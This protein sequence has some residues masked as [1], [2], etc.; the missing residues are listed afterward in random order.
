MRLIDYEKALKDVLNILRG[1]VTTVTAVLVTTA[2]KASTVDA[3]EVVRCKDCEHRKEKT[4]FHPC[5]GMWVGAELKDNDF[6]SYGE[7]KEK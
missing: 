5:S 6:C 4:C 1:K 7:R 2:M 3:V